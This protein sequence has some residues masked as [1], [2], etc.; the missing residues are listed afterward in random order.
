MS[1]FIQSLLDYSTYSPHG[2]CL[3]WQPGLIWLHVFSDAIIAISYFS[4]PFALS[5]FVAKRPDVEFGWVFWAFAIFIMAC[6]FTHIFSILTLWVPVYEMEGAVKALTAVASLVTAVMLWPL[7]PKLLMVP[8]PAQ[9]RETQLALHNETLQRR[10]AEDML[11]QSQ[12]MDAVGQLT[13]GVAHDFNNLLTIIIGNLEIAQRDIGKLRD[14]AEERLRRLISSAMSGAQRAATLTNRLLAFARRQPLDP[15]SSNVDQLLNGMAP[16]FRSTLG[17]T[18]D[19]E[20]VGAG[21][22]WQVE[23]DPGQFEAAILNLVVN[24]RD[25]MPDGG[26]LTIETSNAFLDEGYCR[27]HV[28]VI[29]GQYVQIA[30]TDTGTGMSAEIIS[31]AFEPFFTTKQSGQGTGL[32]LSQVYGFVKQSSGHIKIYSEI[33]EGTT[34]KIYLP[35]LMRAGTVAAQE[36]DAV[37]GGNREENIL[38][39][40]DDPEVRG[41]VVEV[42]Q[43]LGYG[44]L[45]APNADQAL[46]LMS[47]IDG[48]AVDL[49][50]TDIVL[51]GRNG[52]QLADE[53]RIR[54]P[55]LKVLFM[56]G[57]SRNAIVHQGRLDPG[58][59]LIQKPLSQA[60]LSAKVRTVLDRS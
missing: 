28:E 29:P 26:K 27:R 1:G 14:G 42:L 51:P 4:I 48:S 35:R 38:V 49:L 36:S 13:G 5:I 37:V 10:E 34:V 44:V 46:A 59:D 25:A 12:K 3:L 33:G 40:E 32:G 55:A 9:L 58:V 8:S 7:L 22:L 17:E 43:D 47:K 20:L 21:G 52:R 41:Y 45:Q 2:I 60:T 16:F 11:R 56:T 24:A 23:V 39:V 19:L 15:K 50:L 54:R 18:I 53:L 57:Y 6:G 31:R 30:V